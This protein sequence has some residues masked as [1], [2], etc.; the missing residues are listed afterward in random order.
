MP[1]AAIIGGIMPTRP[2]VIVS[3][4]FSGVPPCSQSLSVRFGK[5]LLPRA[6]EPWQAAQ[7]LMNRRSPIAI[8]SWSLASA[9]AG[10]D[11]KRA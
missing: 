3:T 6:S 11:A 5:P 1:T 8:A 10:I 9:S 4:I 2:A 7:L